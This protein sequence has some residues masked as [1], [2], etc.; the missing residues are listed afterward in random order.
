LVELAQL[1]GEDTQEFLQMMAPI[2]LEDTQHILQ[3][4]A[5]AVLGKYSLEIQQGAHTLKGSSASMAMPKLAQL[6][7]ELEIMAKDN[8][9]AEAGQK[10]EQIQAEY[11]RVEAALVELVETAV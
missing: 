11:E 7:R 8:E 5:P 9:L 2:F 6:C 3:K 4:L 10:L 1:V